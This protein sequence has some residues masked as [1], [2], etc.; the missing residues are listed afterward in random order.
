M[1]SR[2]DLFLSAGGGGSRSYSTFLKDGCRL[3]LS[4]L[5]LRVCVAYVRSYT[6]ARACVHALWGI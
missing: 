6:R 4:L 3:N 5:L 2:F 1:D